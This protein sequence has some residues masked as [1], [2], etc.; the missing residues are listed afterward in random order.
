MK[1]MLALLLALCMVFAL[2]AVAASAEGDPHDVKGS[3]ML[4]AT[5][6]EKQLTALKEAFSK[7][8]PNIAFD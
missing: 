3:V 2:C 8:F 5:L 6:K 1:K 7:E 4:Y